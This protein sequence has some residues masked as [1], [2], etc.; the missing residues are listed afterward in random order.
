MSEAYDPCCDMPVR[1]STALILCLHCI[2]KDDKETMAE[3]V[4][5]HRPDTPNEVVH[6]QRHNIRA[7]GDVMLVWFEEIRTW[8]RPFCWCDRDK[9]VRERA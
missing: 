3:L 7:T 4:A 8:E 9:E 5:E 2:L 6:V 1:C